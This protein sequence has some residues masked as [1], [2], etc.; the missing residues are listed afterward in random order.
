VLS[1]VAAAILGGRAPL[2]RLAAIT[3][4]APRAEREADARA[5][6]AVARG[7]WDTTSA[8]AVY[9]VLARDAAARGELE[10]FLLG[11][12]VR[13]RARRAA[14][15]ELVA[16]RPTSPAAVRTSDAFEVCHVRTS[17][18]NAVEDARAGRVDLASAQL[19]RV[20][21]ATPGDPTAHVALGDLH[22]LRAQRAASP[23]E[24]AGELER[25]RQAY[26][27]ALALDPAGADVH[28]QLG[29]LYFQQGDP[30]RARAELLEYLRRAP[31]AAD[32]AR[33]AEYVRELGR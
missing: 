20:L 19:E 9:D 33:V 31:G 16:A 18:D 6:A 3:G 23:A 28:R 21:A 27:R 22:R 26:E 13:L 1:P 24:R 25:A 8:A 32:A 17:R 2:A 15:G 14:I 11:S 29:L 10:V 4:Y 5:V 12:P 30:V 7:G